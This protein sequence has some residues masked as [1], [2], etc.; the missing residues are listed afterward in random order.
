MDD[1]DGDMEYE[2]P[3]KGVLLDDHQYFSEEELEAYTAPK[4]L[5]KGTSKYQSAWFLDGGDDVSDSGSN[6]QIYF[7]A[8]AMTYDM[9]KGR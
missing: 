8:I 2:A 5:P 1:A 7:S 6:L 9:V 3:K 4:K